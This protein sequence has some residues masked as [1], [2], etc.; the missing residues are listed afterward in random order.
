MLVSCV[1]EG[2]FGPVLAHSKPLRWS[3]YTGLGQ[4]RP[5]TSPQ[6]WLGIGSKWAEPVR[7]GVV[8]Q[9]LVHQD[10]HFSCSK[11]SGSPLPTDPAALVLLTEE[12]QCSANFVQIFSGQMCHPDR[13]RSLP[14]ESSRGLHLCLQKKRYNIGAFC[15]FASVL[16][17]WTPCETGLCRTAGG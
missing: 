8:G 14:I 1:W 17:I 3:S 5:P 10:G 4:L 13:R 2:F 11:N 16:Q 15:Y 7:F 12:A 9:C 6:L